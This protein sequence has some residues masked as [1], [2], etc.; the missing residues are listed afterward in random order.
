MKPTNSGL[1]TLIED[2]KRIHPN[3][4]GTFAEVLM[5]LRELQRIRAGMP[6][7]RKGEADDYNDGWND[8]VDAMGRVMK[9]E[10]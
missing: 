7:L 4:D 5:Y 8:C 3:P 9:G 6:K 10:G 2:I 1:A